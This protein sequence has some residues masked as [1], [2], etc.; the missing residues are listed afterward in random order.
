MGNMVSR[1]INKRNIEISRI[2]I[3]KEEITVTSI[4]ITIVNKESP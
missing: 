2:K 4:R 3:E 1:P